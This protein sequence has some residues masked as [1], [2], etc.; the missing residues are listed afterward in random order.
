MFV[1]GE[2][3]WGLSRGTVSKK[4]KE[5][6]DEHSISHAKQPGLLGYDGGFISSTSSEA[7]RRRFQPDDTRTAALSSWEVHNTALAAI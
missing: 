1:C 7:V 5:K 2:P 3:R 4:T 6:N